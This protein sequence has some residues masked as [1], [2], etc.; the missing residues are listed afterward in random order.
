MKFLKRLTNHVQSQVLLDTSNDQSL[1]WIQEEAFLSTKSHIK[2]TKYICNLN[3]PK[4]MTVSLRRM[5]RHSLSQCFITLC[6]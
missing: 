3:R 4:G 1:Q 6:P 5:I 2:I